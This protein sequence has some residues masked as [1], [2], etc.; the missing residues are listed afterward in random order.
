MVSIPN[1]YCY[2]YKIIFVLLLGLTPLGLRTSYYCGCQQGHANHLLLFTIGVFLLHCYLLY[3]IIVRGF[4]IGILTINIL[5]LII[6]IVIFFYFVFQ[7]W[8][9]QKIG[10]FDYK[11][12]SSK[13]RL[14]SRSAGVAH[15]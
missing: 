13:L 5:I 6:I 4:I 3:N 2:L 12:A 15:S 7:R 14:E 1:L 9:K 11:Q 8:L 10:L